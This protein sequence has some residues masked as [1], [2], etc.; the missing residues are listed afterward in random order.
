[1]RIFYLFIVVSLCT[2]NSQAQVQLQDNL[3]SIADSLGIEIPFIESFTT[4]S[5]VDPK[6]AAMFAAVLPGLGKIYNKQHWKI[7]IVYGGFIMFAHYINNNNNLYNAFRNAYTSEI[8]NDPETINPFPQ[9]GESSLQRSAERFRRNRDFVMILMGIFYLVNIVETHVAAHLREFEVNDD[10]AI[11][12]RPSAFSA[13]QFTTRSI[14][15]SIVIP[16][17]K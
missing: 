8:D 10:L 11:K 7:P 12:I 17:N 1:M 4:V 5:K 14:G 3:E 2:L 13:S 16:L 9:F 15:L 6:K